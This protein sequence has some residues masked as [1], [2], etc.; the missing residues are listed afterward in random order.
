MF[1]YPN[2]FKFFPSEFGLRELYG[3][4]EIGMGNTNNMPAIGRF[5]YFIQFAFKTFLPLGGQF[6]I[7]PTV[8][9]NREK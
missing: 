3:S 7:N 1:F 6:S 9:L 8:S 5:P 2:L 4:L